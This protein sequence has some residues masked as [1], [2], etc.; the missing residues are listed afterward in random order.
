MMLVFLGPP[1]SGKGTQAQQL[2]QENGFAHI[3][4]GAIIREYLKKDGA[5]GAEIRTHVEAGGLLP[6]DLVCRIVTDVLKNKDLKTEDVVLDGFPRTLGQAE[7]FQKTLTDANIQ[8]DRVIFFNVG[9]DELLRRIQARRS[10]MTCGY[11]TREEEINT[12]AG[13]CPKCGADKFERRKD[14]E[15]LAFQ[16]RMDVYNNESYPLVAY[17]QKIGL[18]KEIDASRNFID[19]RQQLMSILERKGD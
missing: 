13:K 17:Y 7:W 16:H 8:L 5:L 10:C 11:V 6:D 4:T 2:A 12:N 15:S 1:G 18:L 19:V 9:A 3:S 14:D